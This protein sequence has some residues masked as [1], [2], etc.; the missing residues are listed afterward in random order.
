MVKFVLDGGG[1]LMGPWQVVVLLLDEDN[2]R[3]WEVN[4]E[5]ERL[6]AAGKIPFF[7]FIPLKIFP[8]FSTI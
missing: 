5:K 3:W 7:W 4:N 6:N 2:A 1:D 8:N